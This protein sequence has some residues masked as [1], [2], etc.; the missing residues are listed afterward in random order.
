MNDTMILLITYLLTHCNSNTKKDLIAS[1]LY[2]S[3]KLFSM[4]SQ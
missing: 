1:Y 3:L 4:H 2:L